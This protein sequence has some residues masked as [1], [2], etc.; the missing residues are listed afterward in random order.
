MREESKT[1][2]EPE[3]APVELRKKMAQLEKS[4]RRMQ[5]SLKEKDVLLKEVYH[6]VKNNM[7]FILSLLNLQSQY[8]EDERAREMLKNCQHR[9]R[10]MQLVHERMYQ[11]KD[12]GKIE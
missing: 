2:K 4:K 10:S 5:A 11:S 1:K 8:V 12:S 3:K 9:I 7:Q 6:Q